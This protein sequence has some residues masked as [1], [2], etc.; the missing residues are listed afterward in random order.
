MQKWPSNGHKRFGRMGKIWPFLRTFQCYWQAWDN[1]ILD[2]QLY[3]IQ[4]PI[5]IQWWLHYLLL[6]QDT[7][8]TMG[9]Q[10]V[11]ELAG[12]RVADV[13]STAHHFTRWL[14]PD[15]ICSFPPLTDYW[16]QDAMGQNYNTHKKATIHNWT[17]Q[18]MQQLRRETPYPT[19]QCLSM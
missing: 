9:S 18:N 8:C 12:I 6:S 5:R 11:V 1:S 3:T 17:S 14:L 2:T 19:V 7:G 10:L 13:E 15:S 16:A 4:L